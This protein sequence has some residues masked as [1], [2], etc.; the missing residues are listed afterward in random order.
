MP[1]ARDEYKNLERGKQLVL[2]KGLNYAYNITPTDTDLGMDF[3]HGKL[4]I[5]GELKFKDTEMSKGQKEHFT[6]LVD[7]I[8]PEIPAYFLLARHEVENC[9]EDILA[10]E[11]IVR[12]F[13]YNKRAPNG[14]DWIVLRRTPEMN[15]KNFIDKVLI[16]H[17]MGDYI[18]ITPV[19]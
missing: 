9:M 5:F 1:V 4:F 17:G 2:F 12:S 19:R 18:K 3:A 7:A 8:R 14:S 6:N 13:Y 10:Y 15:V 11:A 16:K